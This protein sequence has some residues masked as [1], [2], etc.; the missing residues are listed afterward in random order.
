MIASAPGGYK[1]TIARQ[2]VADFA[3]EGPRWSA[4]VVALE[5]S[6]ASHTEALGRVM[7]S[8]P[9]IDDGAAQSTS[10]WESEERGVRHITKGI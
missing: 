3:A 2:I 9:D 5:A 4:L 1:T 10:I 6:T 7:M 8:M